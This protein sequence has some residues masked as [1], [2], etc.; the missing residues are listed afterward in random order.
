MATSDHSRTL[1]NYPC[2]SMENAKDDD[3]NLL[4]IV[5]KF[6]KQM[7]PFALSSFLHGKDLPYESCRVFEGI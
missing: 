6:D 1:T 7:D 3:D 5:D 2:V 4:A